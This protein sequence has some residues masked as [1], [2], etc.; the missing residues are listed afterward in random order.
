MSRRPTRLRPSATIGKVVYLGRETRYLVELDAG[1]P[2]RRRRSRISATSSSEALAL[3]GK[4]VRLT[5]KRPHNLA[6]GNDDGASVSASDG[7]PATEGSGG[8]SGG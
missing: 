2:A 8:T 5:W 7:Q 4:R 3:E 1:S 6:L